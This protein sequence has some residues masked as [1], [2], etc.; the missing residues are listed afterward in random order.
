[1]PWTDISKPS[2]RNYTNL[3]FPG[4]ETYDDTSLTY[5][6]SST[7]YDSI[8]QSAWTDI[9]KPSGARTV[10]AGMTMGLLIPLTTSRT[11]LIGGEWTEVNKPT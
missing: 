8:N 6:D 10:V 4:K 9:G 3:S 11:E 2:G 7:F 1:M 5:N